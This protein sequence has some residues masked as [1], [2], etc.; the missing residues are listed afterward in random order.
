MISTGE[1]FM[2]IDLYYEKKLQIARKHT[3]LNM[4]VSEIWMTL[5]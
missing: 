4:D 1:I 3:F 2:H 5:F